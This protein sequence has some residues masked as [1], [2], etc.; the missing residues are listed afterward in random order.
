MVPTMTDRHAAGPAPKCPH[1]GEAAQWFN[2]DPGDRFTPPT[3]AGFYC[4]SC[5]VDVA[6]IPTDAKATTEAPNAQR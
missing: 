3:N 4:E 5:G 1:C 6:E 2:D